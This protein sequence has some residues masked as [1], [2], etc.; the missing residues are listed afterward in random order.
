[1]LKYNPRSERKNLAELCKGSTADSAYRLAVYCRARRLNARKVRAERLASGTVRAANSVFLTVQEKI[2]YHLAELCKGST[3][4]SDSVCLG[5]NPS[6]AAKKSSFFG[7]RIFYP[8]RRL[9][10]SSPREAWCI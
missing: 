2:Q 6:S 8:S 7:T 1:M 3:A 9:G 4:D 10:I 5:S